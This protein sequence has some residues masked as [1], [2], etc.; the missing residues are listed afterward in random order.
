MNA[1]E[2]QN[3]AIRLREAMTN[4]SQWPA[5]RSRTFWLA[6]VV[7][8]VNDHLLKGSGLLPGWLTGKLSD[9][10]GLVVAPVLLA[11][12]L[13]A[14]RPASRATCFAVVY[15]VFAAI[16]LSP[17]AAR[18]LEELMRHV[19]ID[20][21]LWSDPSDL[22][23][24]SV[25]PLAW[26]ALGPSSRPAER[27]GNRLWLL[28]RLGGIAAILA[29]LATS[30]GWPTSISLAVINR[31]HDTV[32]LQVF[33]PPRPLD[34]AAIADDPRALLAA[35]SFA[36]DSCWEAKPLGLPV[37]LDIG[38]VST[39]KDVRVCDAVLLRAER[40]DD[41][42]LFWNDIG[43]SEYDP[44]ARTPPDEDHVVYLEQVGDRLFA[45]APKIVK[46]WQPSF[47]VS[48]ASCGAASP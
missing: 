39:P 35:E 19:G 48:E 26:W 10:A 34:C 9:F 45:D 18:A 8:V 1:G 36:L 28:E 11:S 37:P 46:A 21:R 3:H 29:C 30:M 38:S 24:V 27:T 33:R 32:T 47:K 16:K 15:G 44:Y 12:L 43:S 25:L 17:A 41:T 5:L 22:V 40:L 14:S 2:P 6:L 13:R 31:T 7:L 42:I 20:W 23:A 4:R